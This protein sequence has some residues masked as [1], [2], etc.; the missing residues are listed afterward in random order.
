M[1][2]FYLKIIAMAAMLFD[3]ADKA[4]GL[5]AILAQTLAGSSGSLSYQVFFALLGLIG[6]VSA[7]IFFF[8]IANGYVHTRNR[9][10]YFMRLA[11]CAALSQFPYT[12]FYGLSVNNKDGELAKANLNILFSLALGILALFFYDMLKGKSL[13]AAVFSVLCLSGL[14]IFLKTDYTYGALLFILFFY[15]S[16]SLSLKGKAAAGALTVLAANLL[17]LLSPETLW[18]TLLITFPGQYLGVLFVLFYNGKKGR[19]MKY[20]FYLFYPLHLLAIWLIRMV[21]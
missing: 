12:L 19:S 3:H 9:N 5:R 7:P 6:R 13:F 11:V 8:G 18:S 16:A 15:L 2:L 1:S 14:A 10:R 4:F 17:N 20:A 21:L